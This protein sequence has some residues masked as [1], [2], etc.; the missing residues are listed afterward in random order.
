VVDHSENSL[1]EL[2]RWL[3][4][5]ID[6]LAVDD[7]R[8]LPLDFGSWIMKQ[9]IMEQPSYDVVLNFAALKHVRTEKDSYSLLQMLDTNVVKTARLLGWLNE[10][11]GTG[12]F[13]SVSTDKAANPVNMM[14]ASKRLME[15]VMFSD[16][17]CVGKTMK[18]A[19]A[20]FANVAFSDG[21]LLQS[22][23]KRYE[24]RQPMALPRD[25]RRYFISLEEAGQI[26]LLA[27]FCGFDKLVLIPKLDPSNDMCLLEDVAK[28]VLEYYGV[29]PRFYND[30][31][32]AKRRVSTDF[33]RGYYP[34][35][36][37]ELN[38]SGEKAYEEFVGEGEEAVDIGYN[39][40]M[41]V[42]YKPIMKGAVSG[43]IGRLESAVSSNLDIDSKE[44]L[45]QLVSGVL[46]ELDH[47]ET[48]MNLDQRM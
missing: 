2:V 29:K 4:S 11:G 15:H 10:R 22:F 17:T 12:N 23:L 21:S 44:S 38:T 31:M 3:R 45:V 1:A 25:T 37:T 24:K 13:F 14:G 48:G 7:F 5:D 8:A 18:T 20:R 43:I 19:S 28:A 41:G 26:C 9:F 35:L 27:A 30:E 46:P 16:D 34:L 36:L 39:Q 32:E 6:G 33:D 47:R 40:L 42:K